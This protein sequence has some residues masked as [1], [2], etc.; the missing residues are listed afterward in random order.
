MVTD[1]NDLDHKAGGLRVTNL[2]LTFIATVLLL[3]RAF[4]YNREQD[5]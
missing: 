3:T 5:L 1:I 4:H 2:I